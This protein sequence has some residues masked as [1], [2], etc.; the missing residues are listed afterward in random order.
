[1][2][3][4]HYK[5]SHASARLAHTQM[6]LLTQRLTVL[7]PCVSHVHSMVRHPHCT[8]VQGLWLELH[9]F[10]T[11]S[12]AADST[13]TWHVAPL[14]DT[15]EQ[16][17]QILHHRL[18]TY[19]CPPAHACPPSGDDIRSTR[20]GS[21]LGCMIDPELHTGFECQSPGHH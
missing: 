8:A 10:L 19:W 6:L 14:L 7:T 1:M 17:L 18:S 13:A 12:S 21:F 11:A 15:C 16:Q 4:V 9:G 2:N 3:I 5:S 20:H